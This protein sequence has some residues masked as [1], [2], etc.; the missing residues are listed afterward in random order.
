MKTRRN[1][2]P[3]SRPVAAILI[4]ATTVF[5][6]LGTRCGVLGALVSGSVRE[7]LGAAGTGL[8]VATAWALAFILAT[9]SGTLT[10]MVVSL[11]R[12]CVTPR[13]RAAVVVMKTQAE[14]PPVAVQKLALSPSNRMALKDV[15]TALKN[16]GYEKHEIEPIVSQMDP[17]AGFERNV[18]SA[19][20]ALRTN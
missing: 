7:L 16:L 10:R 13:H 6:L 2:S 5:L 11:W 9:P 20:K 19:L 18:K 14:L 15:S 8:L 4:V 1:A 12:A 17:S 3:K